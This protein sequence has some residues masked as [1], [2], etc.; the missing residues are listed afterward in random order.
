M[1]KLMLVKESEEREIAIPEQIL[2]ALWNGETELVVKYI[3]WSTEYGML[4]STIDEQV[5]MRDDN[6]GNAGKVNLTLTTDVKAEGEL[7]E[8]GF[9]PYMT[10]AERRAK[11]LKR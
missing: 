6:G 9:L 5:L 8:E 2:E 10:I 7:L 3:G 1:I 4:S 11:G